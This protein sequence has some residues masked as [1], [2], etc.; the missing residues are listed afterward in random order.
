VNVLHSLLRDRSSLVDQW[1]LTVAAPPTPSPSRTASGHHSGEHRIDHEP[2]QWRH[3]LQAQPGLQDHQEDTRVSTRP[4]HSLLQNTK[5]PVEKLT[6]E[7]EGFESLWSRED[8]IRRAGITVVP[9]AGFD[10]VPTDCLAAYVAAHLERPRA[11]IIA[12]R[13]AAS[14]SQGP[15]RTA[16]RQVAKPV[17]CRREGAI[18]PLDD[19]SP[20]LV[21]FGDSDEP[22]LPISW[23][24]VATAFH[25]TGI[26]NITVYFRRTRLLRVATD[27]GHLLGRLLR[28][29]PGQRGLA[30]IVRRLPEEPSEST[31][32]KHQSTIWAGVSD[33][34]GQSS[35]ALLQTPDPYD[36]TAHSAVEIASRVSALPSPLGLATPSQA[37]GA[38]FRA[39]SSWM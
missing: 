32:A 7:I 1:T 34:S 28:S 8:E 6:G 23:G 5:R 22:C 37:F 11:L 24:D 18:V 3:G 14:A 19:Q 39:E 30:A 35:S 16:I 17:L 29:R 31:R 2:Q 36:F 9:G 25:R 12:L 4:F 15:M 13:S 20:R 10:V 21:N 27:T 26:E 38:G 33:G